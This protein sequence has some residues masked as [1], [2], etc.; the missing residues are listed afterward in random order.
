MH[1]VF[2]EDASVITSLVVLSQFQNNIKNIENRMVQFFV[3]K[4]PSGCILSLMFIQLLLD[5]AA[6]I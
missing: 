3:Y 6:A 4:I 5:K 2:F 1:R